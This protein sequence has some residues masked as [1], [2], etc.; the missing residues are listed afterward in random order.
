MYVSLRGH[1]RRIPGDGPA[2]NFFQNVIKDTFDGF[3]AI[4]VV[5]CGMFDQKQHFWL[6]PK[7]LV[8]RKELNLGY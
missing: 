3:M 5:K 8:D 2:G 4:S 6:S 1:F 7:F